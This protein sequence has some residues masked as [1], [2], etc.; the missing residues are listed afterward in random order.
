MS[1][2]SPTSDITPGRF[3][4]VSW[5]ADVDADSTPTRTAAKA[6]PPGIIPKMCRVFGIIISD[7]PTAEADTVASSTTSWD[8][9]Y[10]ETSQ[11]SDVGV[12]SPLK[13]LNGLAI[14]GQDEAT[15][16]TEPVEPAKPVE[17]DEPTIDYMIDKDATDNGPYVPSYLGPDEP[18]DYPGNPSPYPYEDPFPDDPAFQELTDPDRPVELPADTPADNAAPLP[19]ELSAAPP[20]RVLLQSPAQLFAQSILV[21]SPDQIGSTRA[22]ALH[23]EAAVQTTSDG[24]D[25]HT[26]GE[27]SADPL[28]ELGKIFLQT[29]SRNSSRPSSRASAVHD[30]WD[31]IQT[32]QAGADAQ[33]RINASTKHSMRNMNDSLSVLTDAHGRLQTAFLDLRRHYDDLCQ[34]QERKA[35]RAAKQQLEQ[36]KRERERELEWRKEEQEWEAEER[37]WAIEAEEHER[38]RKEKMHEAAHQEQIARREEEVAR[39][40]ETAHQRSNVFQTAFGSYN[41]KGKEKDENEMG[42]ATESGA[43]TSTTPCDYVDYRRERLRFGAR[44]EVPS[45]QRSSRVFAGLGGNGD[46][47]SPN[48]V[49]PCVLPVDDCC[50]KGDEEDEYAADLRF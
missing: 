47:N 6:S 2:D 48:H 11:A 43:T 30:P 3:L 44:L 7:T 20:V 8:M 29:L 25:G 24:G 5:P 9:D 41:G 26:E 15:S 12:R 27:D 21:A 22:P 19:A 14:V 42:E 38:R 28:V 33:K 34:E 40:I 31:A 45:L 32:L 13:A 4:Q 37:Q 46:G 18:P 1:E 50:E 49:P 39:R 36:E 35:R 10:C 16:P 23:V 17:Y